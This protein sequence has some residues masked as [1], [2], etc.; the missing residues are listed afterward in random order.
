M[1]LIWPLPSPAAPSTEPP[2]KAMPIVPVLEIVPLL[3]VDPPITEPTMIS[4]PILPLVPPE[5]VI[6][7][8]TTSELTTSVPSC[9]LMLVDRFP[10]PPWVDTPYFPID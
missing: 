7:A 5:T 2:T 10:P 9:P 3:R 1:L 4:D 6:V 8:P